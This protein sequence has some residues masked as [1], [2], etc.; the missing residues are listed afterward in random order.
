MRNLIGTFGLVTL[1]SF[2]LQAEVISS[3]SDKKESK[4]EF[5][6]E[7][8]VRVFTQ[9]SSKYDVE[10]NLDYS[11]ITDTAIELCEEKLAEKKLGLDTFTVIDRSEIG[12]WEDSLGNLISDQPLIETNVECTGMDIDT[13]HLEIIE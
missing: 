12:E 6:S 7:S 4:V 3:G 8:I 1:V 13:V 2:S 11:E 10:G 9:D 5:V